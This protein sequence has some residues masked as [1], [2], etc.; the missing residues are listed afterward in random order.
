MA[1]R[2]K[3]FP[4]RPENLGVVPRTRMV[5]EYPLYMMSPDSTPTLAQGHLFYG[6]P[7]E[8]TTHTAVYS[9]LKAFIPAI[10]DYTQ[11]FRT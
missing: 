1:Q 2:L 7:T 6:S 4:T 5:S 8:M 10:W 3:V 9:Q 11:S